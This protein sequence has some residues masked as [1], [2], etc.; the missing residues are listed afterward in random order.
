MTTE[1]KT[2]RLVSLN[3]IHLKRKGPNIYEVALKQEYLNDQ[4]KESGTIEIIIPKV[5]IEFSNITG[6]FIAT[7]KILA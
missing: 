4:N 7:G 5:M 2:E 1:V 3:D 6:G